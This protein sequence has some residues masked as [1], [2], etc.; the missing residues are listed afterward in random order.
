MGDLELENP[1]AS[2]L[3]LLFNYDKDHLKKQLINYTLI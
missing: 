2:I 3:D 1:Y